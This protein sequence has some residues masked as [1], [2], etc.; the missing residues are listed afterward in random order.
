VN[1]IL[2]Y[3]F[4]PSNL[5]S[6][7]KLAF[8][9]FSDFTTIMTSLLLAPALTKPTPPAG[10]SMP[11]GLSTNPQAHLPIEQSDSKPANCAVDPY[12]PPP[13]SD[14]QFPPFDQDLAVVYRYRQQQGVNLG[15]W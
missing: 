4:V 6:N 10:L 11:A 8:M 12:F 9:L 15:S 1:K 5:D 2:D 7:N 14:Q 13:I 3:P